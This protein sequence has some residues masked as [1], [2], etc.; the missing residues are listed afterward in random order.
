MTDEVL[1]ELRNIA[2]LLERGADRTPAWQKPMQVTRPDDAML[3][4]AGGG[5]G[6]LKDVAGNLVGVLQALSGTWRL[7]VNSALFN[8][9]DDTPLAIDAANR[10]EVAVLPAAPPG[11]STPVER[12]GSGDV[13][14]STI[15]DD[16]FV[17][18]SGETLTITRF[19]AGAEGSGK[20]SKVELYYDPAGTGVGMSII[21]IAYLAD[22]TIEFLFEEQFVGDGT[23]AIR[24]RRTRLDSGVR[25]VFGA[26]EGFSE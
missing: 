24:L 15:V 21:R 10:L 13:G 23:A 16:V 2:R 3:D 25:E 6:I 8:P 4:G 26:W 18:A 11:G 1:R 14:G 19:L 17:I 5:G 20:S 7:A 22:N 9:A 12:E